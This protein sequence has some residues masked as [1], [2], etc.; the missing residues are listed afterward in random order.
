M[1]TN[2]VHNP[3]ST[4]RR[5]TVAELLARERVAARRVPRDRD[6]ET[7]RGYL[8]AAELLRREGIEFAGD[9]SPTEDLP[10]VTASVPAAL[11]KE[12]REQPTKGRALVGST[13]MSRIALL[14]LTV[15]GLVALKPGIAS[16]PE[17]PAPREG[18][19]ALGAQGGVELNTRTVD[20]A[21]SRPGGGSTPTTAAPSAPAE[22]P[23]AGSAAAPQ[24]DGHTPDRDAAVTTAAPEP[25][26]PTTTVP[27]DRIDPPAP[28]PQRP[29]PDGDPDGGDTGD[30]PRDG[31][32]HGGPLDPVLDPVTGAIGGV[33]DLGGNLL[34][35]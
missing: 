2:V 17:D 4:G 14:G 5:P 27:Q 30:D 35:G 28:Q 10:A 15:A 29:A 33:L 6:Y 7:P 21:T 13:A 18:G 11:R 22:A 19:R 20:T 34:G 3:T 24:T 31:G 1:P 9:E 16:T 12:A 25:A 8:P 26:A 32:D 23:E